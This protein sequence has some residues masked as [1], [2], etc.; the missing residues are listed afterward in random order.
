MVEQSACVYLPCLIPI[1]VLGEPCHATVVVL[2]LHML[3]VPRSAAKAIVFAVTS[4]D[5][6]LMA[7]LNEKDDWTR[8]LFGRSITKTKY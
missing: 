8:T 4:N 7:S 6:E 5:I 1:H 3:C 2:Y